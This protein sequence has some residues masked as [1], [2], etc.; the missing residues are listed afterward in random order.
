MLG[1]LANV[2]A[3]DQTYRITDKN[4]NEYENNS[5]HYFNTYGTFENAVEEA[6]LYLVAHNDSPETIYVAGEIVEIVNT[7]GELGQFCIGGMWGNCFFPLIVGGYYP[8]NN[9]GILPGNST[10][11]TT[12][13]LINLDPTEGAR[14]KVR[15]TEKNN[16]TGEDIPN[17]N[18][19]ITYVY[20][21][22]MA[23]ADVNSKSIAEVYPT[24]AKGF[25]NVNVSENAQVQVVNALGKV[26]KTTSF[27]EGTHKL[28]LSGMAAGVYWVS[29]KG[30]SGKTTSIKIV[31]K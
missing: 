7:T 10:W 14:Y 9:G 2:F 23:V 31:V 1:A 28:D 25:T 13:Y 18:F 5:T 15:F 12:D 17:T 29:F 4:G 30:Q 6:K 22:N 3:Q 27:N 26:V 24:V 11:G 21:T 19:F 16:A 20:S 8:A